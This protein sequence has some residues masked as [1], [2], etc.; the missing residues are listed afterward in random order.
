MVY[1][2]EGKQRALLEKHRKEVPVK[3]VPIAND[4]GIQVYSI[5]WDNKV[6]GM[7][8]KTESGGYEIYTN[9]KH[10]LTRR[11]FTIAH[12]ISHYLL[13]KELMDNEFYED[14][15]LRASGA[16]SNP[17]I[18]SEANRLAADILMPM[19]LIW[20]EYERGCKTIEELAERFQVSKD[21]MSVRLLGTHY[22][23]PK[24]P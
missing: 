1:E 9:S 11:R 19:N 2:L 14:Y 6:S 10:P 7:I 8:R 5:D 3:T 18:E 17:A 20:K 21:A 12:E 22:R 13:H 23:S 24:K 4:L 16:W 15:L